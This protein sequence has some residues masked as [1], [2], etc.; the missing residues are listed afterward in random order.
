MKLGLDTSVLVRLITAQPADQFLRARARL[1]TAAAAGDEILL[2]DLVI[3][4]CCF[5]LRA[6]Y[7]LGDAEVR[8][9]LAR[10]IQSGVFRVD[11]AEASRALDAGGG[12]GFAD[13]LIHLRYRTLGATTLTL[14]RAQVRLEGAAPV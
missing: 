3:A 2:T 13:R 12:A 6:H 11:P 1:E 8:R 7:G 9:A 5:V 14:D 4:E 10:V